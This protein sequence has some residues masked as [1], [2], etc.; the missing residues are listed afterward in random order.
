[1]SQ[2]QPR[3]AQVLP[4]YFGDSFQFVGRE[5]RSKFLQQNS[6]IFRGRFVQREEVRPQAAALK[7]AMLNYGLRYFL[8][9]AQKLE[10]Q[11]YKFCNEMFQLLK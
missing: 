6:W 5:Q 10:S 7:K 8:N 9:L 3:R 1:V 4:A 2:G 11:Y